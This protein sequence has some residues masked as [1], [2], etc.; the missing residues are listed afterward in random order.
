MYLP[1]I[2]AYTVTNLT[3]TTITN[4]HD[5]KRNK[6]FLNITSLPPWTNFRPTPRSTVLTNAPPSAVHRSMTVQVNPT[7]LVRLVRRIVAGNIT[8]RA[9]YTCVEILITSCGF[10]RGL[11]IEDFG[12]TAYSA[13]RIG[14]NTGILF[15]SGLVLRR[16]AY[17]HLIATNSVHFLMYYIFKTNQIN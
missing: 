8:Q 16:K 4:L 6:Y 5:L 10:N 11:W 7:A 13:E 3:A 15:A 1:H 12:T 9:S 17:P 2:T 14:S